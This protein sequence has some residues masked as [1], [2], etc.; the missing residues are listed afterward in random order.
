MKKVLFTFILGLLISVTNIQAQWTQIGQEIK[1]VSYDHLGWST[2]L[3][4]DGSILA[5]GANYKYVRIYKNIGGTWTQIGQDIEKEQSASR[6]GWSISL[7]SDGTIVAIGIPFYNGI[8]T[9]SGRVKIYKNVGGV[10][11]Q[12]GQDIDGEAGSDNLGYSVSL[13]S[14][15]TTVA[16]GI[17]YGYGNTI[18]SGYIRVFKNIDGTWTQIGQD[19]DG[20]ARGDKAG[21]SV[22]LS[23]DGSIVATSFPG[24]DENGTD[25][26]QVRVFK[27]IG[28]TWTQIGQNIDG[29]E[30]LDLCGISVS[31]SSDGAVVAV[32]SVVSEGINGF[33]AGQVR[34]FKN[35]GGTW[36]QIGQNIEGEDITSYLGWS[37]SLNSDGSIVA[38]SA[39][40]NSP[41]YIG[42]FKNIGGT[43]TKIDN[44]IHESSGGRFGQSVSLNSDGSI[45]AIGAPSK[46]TNSKGSVKVFQNSSLKKPQNLSSKIKK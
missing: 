18:H 42:V 7:S 33:G 43:W 20:E 10:W 40:Y 22:S 35:I 37:V 15:G 1:G 8:G 19:I 13:S 27:N 17:P 3:S 16:I 23:S 9:T 28:G 25:S 24:N 30:P 39:I 45:V 31:L 38:T 29:E 4:S 41:S 12:I 6:F 26:G 32:S 36:T 2:S 5:V 14:D 21:W 44:Y 11:T 34:V 46:F